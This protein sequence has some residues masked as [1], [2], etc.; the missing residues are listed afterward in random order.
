MD[1]IISENR[2]KVD[3]LLRPVVKKDTKRIG[4][5]DLEG[6]NSIDWMRHTV[7]ISKARLERV[8]ALLADGASRL[9]VQP[10]G[11]PPMLLPIAFA[12][13]VRTRN[14]LYGLDA[15]DADFIL[16]VCVE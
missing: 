16:T 8:F 3:R 13:W 7:P 14:Q 10:D 9:S 15:E 1:H 2:L 4:G 5:N 11:A 6:T 12:S